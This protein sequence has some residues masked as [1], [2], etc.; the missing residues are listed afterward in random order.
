[1]KLGKQQWIFIFAIGVVILF[2]AAHNQRSTD[3]RTETRTNSVSK[4]KTNDKPC[5][6]A[7][8]DGTMEITRCND[9]E[10]LCKDYIFYRK[11]ILQAHR[12][13]DAKKTAK[14]RAA[15]NKVLYWLEEYNES[16]IQEM[17]SKVE[18]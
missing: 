12:D 17:M 5:N 11:K 6:I 14:Y 18:K 13:G 3:N 4:V 9:L 2:A 16:D 10:E 8:K 15:F 7:K 1:M